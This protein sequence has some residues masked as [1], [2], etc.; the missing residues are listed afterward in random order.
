[1]TTPRS[2]GEAALEGLFLLDGDF[3][4]MAVT[5]CHRKVIEVSRDKKG[6]PPFLGLPFE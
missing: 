1:M 2:L 3:E 5:E 6:E 4:A